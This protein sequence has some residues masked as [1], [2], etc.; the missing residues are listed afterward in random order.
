MKMRTMWRAPLAVAYW[1]GAIGSKAFDSGGDLVFLCHGTPQRIAGRLELQLRYLRRSFAIVPFETIAASAADGP[2]PAQGRRAAIVFDDGMRNNVT[3]AYPIL[4]ALGVPATFFVCPGLIGERKWIWTREARRRLQF[5]APQ[6]RAD[7]ARALGAP[8]EVEQ[9][10]LWMKRLQLAER[11]NAEAMLRHATRK[12]TPSDADRD[13]FDLAG[14]NDLRTLD[15]AVVSIGSHSLTHPIL[16][17]LSNAAIEVEL[18]ESRRMLEA[19]L[20]RAVEFFSYPD[21]GVDWRVLAAARR[22]YRGAVAHSSGMPR[23]AHMVPSIH[24]PASVL[25]LALDLHVPAST[26]TAPSRPFLG[27]GTTAL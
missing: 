12:F 25:R 1:L 18:R 3:V 24:L 8:Q 19:R 15:P 14:W 5:A 27:A 23:D 26:T 17:T 4:R 22:H 7:L 9:F 13:A 6:L 2:R 16:P 10:I 11:A 21:S 20:D